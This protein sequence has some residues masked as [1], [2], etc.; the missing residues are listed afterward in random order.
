MSDVRISISFCTIREGW[1][2][3]T[4]RALGQQTMPKELFEFVMVDDWGDRWDQVKRLAEEN[5]VNVKYMK[6]K[7]WHWKSN[8][9]LGNARNTGFIHCDGELVVFL[10]DYSW[11][12]PTF[13]ATHWDLYKH[14]RRAVIGVVQAVE[15]E[16]GEVSSK[17]DLKTVENDRDERWKSIH[18]KHEKDDCNAGWFW[19]FNASAPMKS[20]IRVNGYDERFDCAGEDDVDLG[21]RLARIGVKFLYTSDPKIKVYHMKHN[22]G[23]SRPSPFPPEECDK[24]TKEMLNVKYDGSWG[25]MEDNSRRKPWMVNQGYFS[26]EEARKNRGDYQTR[27][28]RV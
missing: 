22:G 19:T 21:L 16:Y 24:F 7:P 5:D 3:N 12:E 1:L 11:V 26:L 27:R 10:D 23:Q 18:P 13:L 28:H 4:F 6:S 2:G 25:L 8:R 9:Q 15:P 20:I 14:R 17:A